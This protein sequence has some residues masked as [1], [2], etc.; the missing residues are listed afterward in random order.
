MK[1]LLALAVV[2]AAMPGTALAQDTDWRATWGSGM[3]TVKAENAEAGLMQS[4]V[5]LTFPDLRAQDQTLREFVRTSVGGDAVRIRLTNA[6]GDG[7]LELG[8]VTVAVQAD[9]AAVDPKT[10]RVA[11]FDGA[12]ATTIPA[13]EDLTSDPVD[14]RVGP[15]QVLAI[16]LHVK[17]SPP[18]PTLHFLALTGSTTTPAGAGDHAEDPGGDAFTQGYRHWPWLTGVDVRAPAETGSV[19]AFGDSITDGAY[20]SNA[21]TESKDQSWP[22]RLA[23]RLRA[24]DPAT[25]A[26]G[27]INMGISANT[28]V[29]PLAAWTGEPAVVRWDR[30]TLT[31]TG[32]THVLLFEGTNDLGA[33]TPVEQITA[34]LQQLVERAHA[35]GLRVVGATIPPRSDTGWSAAR[36][37]NRVAL[38]AW[39]RA[40]DGY[41]GLVDFEKALADPAQPTR[42]LPAYDSGDGLHPG[43]AGR[44]AMADAVDLDLLRC[45]A[46]PVL[47]VA[48]TSSLRR[49]AVR[50]RGTLA[51]GRCRSVAPG[52][53]TVSVARLTGKGRCR[54]VTRAGRLQTARPCADRPLRQVATGRAAW[55]LDRS[56]R[57]PAGH[58]RVR[59]RTTAG[60]TTVEA[61]RTIRVPRR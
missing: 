37:P 55:R 10:L 1:R 61:T 53:V 21:F 35:R 43:P 19:V 31:R 38:N 44:Q 51:P 58:Y 13:G 27:V 24:T 8:T 34:G 2:L 49:G 57:L 56:W 30:D 18:T 3:S 46:D 28:V 54:F 42:L 59:A 17:R 20:I 6:L 14:L 33:D 40:Y 39:I 23:A 41:D 15:E 36:E 22:S 26:R 5:R 47:A 7:P 4:Y 48:R 16:S 45:T 9:G 32:A 60:T 50:L 29:T 12:T 25:H 11:R 52:R